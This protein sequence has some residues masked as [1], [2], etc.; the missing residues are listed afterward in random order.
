MYKIAMIK[1]KIFLEKTTQLTA[2]YKCIIFYAA[3]SNSY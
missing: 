2:Y 3:S 1:Y